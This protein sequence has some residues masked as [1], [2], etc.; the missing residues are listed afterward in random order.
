MLINVNATTGVSMDRPLTNITLRGIGF[1]D[2][3]WTML[4]PHG[5]P[6]GGDWALERMGW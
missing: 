2:A 1:R 3:A 5:I 6:S 4:E